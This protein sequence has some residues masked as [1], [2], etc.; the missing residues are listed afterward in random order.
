MSNLWT[1]IDG[2]VIN[3]D[4]VTKI[5]DSDGDADTK[6]ITRIDF[7]DGE[8]VYLDDEVRDRFLSCIRMETFVTY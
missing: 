6:P 1:V 4:M 7:V 5:V 2:V 3:M 8:H